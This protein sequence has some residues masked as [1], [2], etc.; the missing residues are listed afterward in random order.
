[1]KRIVIAMCI[2]AG[3]ALVWDRVDL[4]NFKNR[5]TSKALNKVEA[6]VVPIAVEPVRITCEGCNVQEQMALDAFQ[7][8]G[9]TD[10]LALAALMGNVKQES[11]FIA[12]ICE[13]GARIPYEQCYRGGYGLIQWTTV[14]RYDGLG[15]YAKNKSCNPSTTKC[16]LGYLFTEYQWKKVAPYMKQGGKTIEW[17]MQHAY[18][19]LGWGVHG[20]RTDYAY[21]Y[22]RMLV[23]SQV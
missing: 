4:E 7:D 14:N 12:N 10:R 2:A 11:K 17:Y 19:W 21:D 18:K 13:G 15:H 8:Q 5:P 9:I 6:P 3:A 22:S 1:M 20:A 23:P 16:Q